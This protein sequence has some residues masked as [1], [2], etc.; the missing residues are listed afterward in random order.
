MRI[1]FATGNAGKLREIRDIMK[2]VGCPIYSNQDLGLGFSVVEDGETFGEN[3]FI[4][5]SEIYNRLK[6]NRDLK[7]TIVMADDSGLSI[8]FLLG[9]PGIKSSRF[10]GE[11]TAYYIKNKAILEKLKDVP[12]E[13]RGAS[14]ICHVTALTEDGERFD[15]EE[16]I[17]GYI[18]HE[19]RG[20]DG[21]GYD[22]IFYLKDLG[23]TQAELCEREK[24]MI[25]H[26]GRALRK[27]MSILIKNGFIKA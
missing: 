16:N 4:K 23:K 8:D 21:F 27:M 20:L 26:R 15:T 14:F 18:S 6:T 3:A 24:N 25:S 2:G 10:M 12:D 7:E 11:E 22:P 17:R 19:I 1:V 5:A 9:A 13:K